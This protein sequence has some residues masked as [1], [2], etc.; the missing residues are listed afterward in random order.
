MKLKG[1]KEEEERKKNG[2]DKDRYVHQIELSESY[3]VIRIPLWID[4]IALVVWCKWHFFIWITGTDYVL[5]LTAFLADDTW[6]T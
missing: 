4:V 6:I 3:L 2:A 1:T 5:D